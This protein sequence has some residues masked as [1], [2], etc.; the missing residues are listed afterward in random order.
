MFKQLYVVTVRIGDDAFIAKFESENA[1][2]ACFN[3]IAIPSD[4]V[5]IEGDTLTLPSSARVAD[6]KIERMTVRVKIGD[7]SR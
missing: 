3:R 6:V 2:L 4:D 1:A 5:A 7:P